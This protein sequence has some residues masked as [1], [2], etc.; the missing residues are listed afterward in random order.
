M[1]VKNLSPVYAQTWRRLLATQSTTKTNGIA[2]S[3]STPQHSQMY[4][5][6]RATVSKSMPQSNETSDSAPGY[7]C[8]SDGTCA[9]GPTTGEDCVVGLG[10]IAVIVEVGSG[11]LVG[12]GA[13][14]GA[15]VDV[16]WGG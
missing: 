15:V 1:I 12:S 16:A 11:V 14:G 6:P 7:R 2:R 13:A 8:V 9:V 4:E 3:K 10:A 5:T